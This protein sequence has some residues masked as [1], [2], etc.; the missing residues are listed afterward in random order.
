MRT[1][2][3]LVQGYL[4]KGQRKQERMQSCRAKRKGERLGPGVME[5]P[6][7]SGFG[8]TPFDY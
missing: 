5:S 6:G 4:V 1:A 8:S 7:Y 2:S 3:G